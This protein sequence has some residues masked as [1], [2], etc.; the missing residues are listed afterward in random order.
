M[1]FCGYFDKP[2]TFQTFMGTKPEGDQLERMTDEGEVPFSLNRLGASFAFQ[3]TAVQSRV[4]VSFISSEQAC[5]NVNDEIPEGTE[6]SDLRDAARRDWE[7]KVLG[8]I[9][10]TEEDPEKLAQL[11]SALY[12]MNLLPTNKTGENPLWES[13]EPYYDDIFTFWDT[14][15]ACALSMSGPTPFPPSQRHEHPV[16]LTLHSSDAQLPSST[17]SSRKHTRSSSARGWTSGATRASCPTAAR[18]SGAV[19]CRL[20]LTSTTC[21]PTRTSR[22][23]AARSTGTTHTRPWSRMPRW[24]RLSTTIAATQEARPSRGEGR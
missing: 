12:F 8:K 13:E 10:T 11:Y 5:R 9:T 4:G 2:A 16:R 24:Y 6:L 19:P 3:D 22:A 20:A 7:D 17:S 21:L 18:P 14:V 1:Y 23:C 15:S